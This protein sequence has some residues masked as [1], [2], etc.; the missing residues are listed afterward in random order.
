MRINF[1]VNPV[2]SITIVH[3]DK[4]LIVFGAA[5]R[6]DFEMIQIISIFFML[7]LVKA[8][9]YRI[10]ITLIKIH[11]ILHLMLNNLIELLVFADVYSILSGALTASCFDW[12]EFYRSLDSKVRVFQQT[13]TLELRE[14]SAL[15]DR[16]I[17]FL[18]GGW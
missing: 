3:F 1:L 14:A 16:R 5:G 10:E 9:S 12:F 15:Q 11:F 7:W 8:F 4:L 17:L 2:L 6:G 18:Y 13:V